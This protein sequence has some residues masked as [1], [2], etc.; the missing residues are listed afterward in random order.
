MRTIADNHNLL[1]SEG[2]LVLDII[3]PIKY[4]ITLGHEVL[5]GEQQLLSI[6]TKSKWYSCFP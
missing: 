2:I 5:A 6:W 1:N 4:V 3:T